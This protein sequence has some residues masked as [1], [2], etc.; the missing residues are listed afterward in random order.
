MTEWVCA[1][2]LEPESEHWF[3]FDEWHPHKPVMIEKE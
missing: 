1:I 3:E 2:C